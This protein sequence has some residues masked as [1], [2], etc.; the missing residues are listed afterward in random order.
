MNICSHLSLSTIPTKYIGN[1]KNLQYNFY[2]MFLLLSLLSKTVLKFFVIKRNNN[3]SFHK[4]EGSWI[5]DKQDGKSRENICTWFGLK[6]TAFTPSLRKHRKCP[7]KRVFSPNINV[8]LFCRVRKSF[9]VFFWLVKEQI[10]NEI[11]KTSVS[12]FED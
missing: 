7:A 5:F 4:I 6:F 8:S 12:I 11:I 3:E 9:D 2:Y 1:H 10:L